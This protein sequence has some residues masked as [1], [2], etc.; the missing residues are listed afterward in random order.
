[1]GSMVIELLQPMLGVGVND[2]TDLAANA[3]GAMIGATAAAA[4]L[5]IADSIRSRRWF[6]ARTVRV[7]VAVVIVA[8]II[9]GI[10]SL[11]ALQPRAQDDL[12]PVAAPGILRC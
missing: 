1:M 4:L 8:A 5:L 12:L 11:L 10:G 6:V 9:T 3:T 7:I 2:L